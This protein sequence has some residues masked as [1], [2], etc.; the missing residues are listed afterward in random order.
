MSYSW[1][2]LYH[3]SDEHDDGGGFDGFCF[4]GTN[5]SLGTVVELQ[6]RFGH[7]DVGDAGGFKD[8]N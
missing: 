3:R 2:S 5:H 7:D 8:L 1:S 6:Q 4:F